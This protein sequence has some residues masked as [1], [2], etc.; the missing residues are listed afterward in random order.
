MSP[1]RGGESEAL[2]TLWLCSQRQSL[3]SVVKPTLLVKASSAY[4]SIASTLALV[5]AVALVGTFYPIINPEDY[6][7]CGFPIIRYILGAPASLLILAA[8]WHFNCKGTRRKLLSIEARDKTL[9][10]NFGVLVV[11][12]ACVAACVVAAVFWMK[13]AEDS[14]EGKQRSFVLDGCV[15]DALSP[16]AQALQIYSEKHGG[17]FCEPARVAEMLYA[18]EDT[19]YLYCMSSKQPFIWNPDLSHIP[20]ASATKRP[21][22]WCPPGAHGRYLGVM[23][24]FQGKIDCDLTTVDELTKMTNSMPP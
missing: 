13:S 2:L 18:P 22:A 20:L 14:P 6:G 17:H 24:V 16:L 10:F 1:L 4:E 19:N 23:T 7:R 5:G 9:L 15:S 21:L 3:I 12:L 11:P 8:A